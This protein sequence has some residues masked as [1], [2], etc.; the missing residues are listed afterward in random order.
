[1]R[2][3]NL[4]LGALVAIGIVSAGILVATQADLLLPPASTRA[5]LVDQLFRV[6]L[7]ISTVIFLLVEGALV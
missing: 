4:F 1:M 2:E 7:G 6:L 5:V 3:R